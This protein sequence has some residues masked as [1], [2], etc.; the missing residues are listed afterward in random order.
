MS[1]KL[2]TYYEFDESESIWKIDGPIGR[3]DFVWAQLAVLFFVVP[4]ILLKLI[5]LAV[6]LFPVVIILLLVGFWLSF[7]AFSKRFY[8]LFGS[9]KVGVISSIVLTIL[10]GVIPFIGLIMLLVGVFVPGKLLIPEKEA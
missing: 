9:L 10:C 2:H 6:L 3:K 4:V 7:A 8:D 1:D 5:G